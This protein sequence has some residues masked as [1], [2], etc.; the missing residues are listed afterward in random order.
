MAPDE[1]DAPNTPEA[2]Y[3]A[4]LGDIEP[5]RP[6]LTGDVFENVLIPGI[7]DGTGLAIL[8]EHPCAMREGPVL[9][10]R[11]LMARVEEDP[12]LP[13]PSKWPTGGLYDYFFLPR[14]RNDETRRAAALHEV[15]CVPTASINREGRIACLS[16]EGIQILLQRLIHRQT[17]YKASLPR[18][19]S[20]IAGPL[21]EIE[22]LGEWCEELVPRRVGSGAEI[23]AAIEK[24]SVEFDAFLGNGPGSLRER[25]DVDHSRADVRRQVRA[26]IEARRSL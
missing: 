5:F 8:L 10:D 14:L 11:L 17:R 18:I 3:R 19:H 25:L 26:E 12:G 22:L 1:L 9:R 13:R 7:P 24:E 6:F 2:I 15:G 16:D 20:A 4:R 21:Y 23:Q